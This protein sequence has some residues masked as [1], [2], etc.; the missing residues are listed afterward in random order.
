[1]LLDNCQKYIGI[2]LAIIV[3]YRKRL[4]KIKMI[5]TAKKR[6]PKKLVV[7]ASLLVVLVLIA[8]VYVYGFNGNLFG[9]RSVQNTPAGVN[10]GPATSDQQKNGTTIKSNGATP[11]STSGSD[12]PSA[13][14][15]ISG[16]TQKSVS[17]TITS[18]NQNGST[19]QIRALIGAVEDTGTCTLTLSQT[20]HQTVT[21]TAGIQALASTSTCQGFD[22]PTSELSTGVWHATI[23]YDSSTLTGA[24][25]KDVTIQ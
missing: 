3:Y 2:T 21:K 17:V 7:I 18:A 25:T 24:T 12:Q 13:P 4:I 9:L 23:T 11:S 16:S 6:F 5:S 20:G 15:P 19:L 1:M 22:V 14:T 10:Y 8:F